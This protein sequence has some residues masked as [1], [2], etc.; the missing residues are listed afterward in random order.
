MTRR[1]HLTP[2]DSFCHCRHRHRQQQASIGAGIQTL[3]LAEAG[4]VLT[5]RSI[6]CT[7]ET[8]DPDISWASGIADTLSAVW[9]RDGTTAALTMV[10]AAWGRDQDL[11]GLKCSG[12]ARMLT[13][14]VIQVPAQHI[15][16][17]IAWPLVQEELHAAAAQAVY[18]HERLRW[19]LAI[20]PLHALAC[21]ATMRLM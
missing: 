20:R 1:D 10:R 15:F 21:N 3:A 17:L 13:F 16:P 12:V 2:H 9:P 5:E 11:I 6:N 19:L 7:C 14:P 18:S 8:V 4:P